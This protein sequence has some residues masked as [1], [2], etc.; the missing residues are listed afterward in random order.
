MEI[1]TLLSA[2]KKQDHNKEA[3]FKIGTMITIL[4]YIIENR[5]ILLENTRVV[6]SV[7]EIKKEIK[8]EMIQDKTKTILF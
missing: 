4:E 5:N 7:D 8:D 3:T 2:M 1:K 6:P